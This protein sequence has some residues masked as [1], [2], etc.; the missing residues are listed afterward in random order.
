MKTAIAI[1]A[2]MLFLLTACSTSETQTEQQ[3]AET[4]SAFLPAPT[5][6]T[7]VADQLATFKLLVATHA[8]LKTQALEQLQNSNDLLDR[9]RT[10]STRQE[11]IRCAFEV[12]V[13]SCLDSMSNWEQEKKLSEAIIQQFFALSE[14][15]IQQ[16]NGEIEEAWWTRSEAAVS[17]SEQ[18]KEIW[19]AIIENCSR[20]CDFWR[21]YATPSWQH[22][23]RLNDQICADYHRK[24]QTGR[25]AYP[26][27][28][29][30]QYLTYDWTQPASR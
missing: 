15:I 8:T 14:I 18:Q 6:E 19:I 26:G 30:D 17:L 11:R 16:T 12:G 27:H 7:D 2:A 13:P 5:T 29:I 3:T 22:Y 28:P 4:G 25:E 20:I 24:H 1:A 23:Y 21:D 10:K 9:C